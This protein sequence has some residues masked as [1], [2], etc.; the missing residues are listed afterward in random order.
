MAA[1]PRRVTGRR[2]AAALPRMDALAAGVGEVLRRELPRGARIAV[3]L[4]GGMDS[5]VLLHVLVR[6]L[7]I[8]PSRVSAIHVNHRIS[9]HAGRWAAFCRRLCRTLG[10]RLR[11]SAVTV[12]HGN[13][14]EAAARA[15]RYAAFA[16]S[17]AGVVVLAHNRDDQ[18]ETV[19][20][21]L[22]RGA[23]PRGLAAMPVVRPAVAGA[24]TVLRPML[25]VPRKAIAD[26]ALRHRLQWVEDESN[27]NPAY[28]RNFLR[29]E[30]VPVIARKVPGAG[31]TLARAARHQAEASDLLDVLAAQDA[32]AD[33]RMGSLALAPLRRLAPHRARNVLRYFLRCNAVAMPDAARL[34]EL[35]RQVLTARDDAQVRVIIG[36][37]DLRRFQDR[38]HLV[39]PL[40][41][42]DAAFEV[43]WSGRGRLVLPQ[44][45]G[46]LRFVRQRGAGIAAELLRSTPLLVRAR[47][48]G[49]SLRL[50]AGSRRRTVR[51]LLQE[52]GLPPWLRERLPFIYLDGALAAVPGVGVDARFRCGPSVSG[53]VPLWLP[54]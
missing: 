17:G 52:A 42:L 13:S 20:L 23:G 25:D 43:A 7:R 14:T 30:V 24:P 11:V 48:G 36:E 38:I 44:L 53:L 27:G 40:P 3:G 12:M 4:S 50:A 8:A 29:H 16:R 18:A 54:D 46:T 15:A 45:G 21:Q 37:V 2:S 34:E 6:Q 31:A 35:A 9:P 39:R 26:Y 19:L 33:C 5:V 47:R 41:P 10:V 32:G 51:N 22:L 49:A 1:R 28:L